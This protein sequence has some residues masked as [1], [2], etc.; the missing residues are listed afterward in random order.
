MPDPRENYR[1]S[2]EKLTPRA[3]KETCTW[4]EA[5]AY[6]DEQI[7]EDAAGQMLLVSQHG[8]CITS[9]SPHYELVNLIYFSSE[10][11]GW[12]SWCIVVRT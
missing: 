9:I 8:F 11:K 3:R 6:D 4:G 7:A 1:R 10:R 2:R 5:D 12:C